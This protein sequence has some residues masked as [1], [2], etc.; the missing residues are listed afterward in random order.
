MKETNAEPLT[1]RTAGPRPKMFRS[2][3]SA[4]AVRRQRERRESRSQSQGSIRRPSLISE[5]G[6][7]VFAHEGQQSLLATK[8][9]GVTMFH[10]GIVLI[11]FGT[12]I[13][14]TSFIPSNVDEQQWNDILGVGCFLFLLGAFLTMVNLLTAKREEQ[15]LHTYVQRRL[16]KSPSSVLPSR[17]PEWGIGKNLYVPE[18]YLDRSSP[19]RHVTY[20]DDERRKSTSSSNSYRKQTESPT[21][22]P[23]NSARD[24]SPTSSRARPL[25]PTAIHTATVEESS[26]LLQPDKRGSGGRDDRSPSPSRHQHHPQQTN[27]N[28]F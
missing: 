2:V 26:N 22:L 8:T 13:I 17:D 24:K 20:A 6:G 15:N 23:A 3:Q 7:R 10:I 21:P 1:P 18:A 12:I 4:I 19:T 28:N 14:I 16:A 25:T 5:H 11:L 9:H 27:S